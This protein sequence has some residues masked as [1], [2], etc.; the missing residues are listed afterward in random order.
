[1]NVDPKLPTA[2]EQ[3]LIAQGVDV[4]DDN[5]CFTVTDLDQDIAWR[6]MAISMPLYY[7]DDQRVNKPT[8]RA[9]VYGVVL[10]DR[11]VAGQPFEFAEIIW[12]K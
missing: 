8:Y 5:L 2:E 11:G 6:A 1:M 7:R 12:K 9:F 4:W 3:A 10:G